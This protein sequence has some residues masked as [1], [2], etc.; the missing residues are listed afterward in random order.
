[1]WRK[2]TLEVTVSGLEVG[3]LTAGSH[4]A[5]QSY[6]RAVQGLGS[7]P[8]SSVPECRASLLWV[9]FDHPG[10]EGCCRGGTKPR[11]MASGQ[12]QPDGCVLAASI[13]GFYLKENVTFS[14][15]N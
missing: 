8:E 11:P 10:E 13:H 3:S 9:S 5:L 4:P 15:D 7:V 1:M 2:L 14:T 6:S 12:G